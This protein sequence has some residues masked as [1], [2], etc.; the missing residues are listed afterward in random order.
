[1]KH[2]L[3]AGNVP[4]NLLDILEAWMLLVPNKGEED[5]L[6]GVQEGTSLF[7]SDPNRVFLSPSLKT[8]FTFTVPI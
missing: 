7:H 4:D 2:L 6:A 5:A 8:S 3:R 1:M